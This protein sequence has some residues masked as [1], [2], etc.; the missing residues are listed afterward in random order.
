MVL[1]ENL[2]CG[3]SGKIHIHD[4][5]EKFDFAILTRKNIFLVFWENKFYDFD[6]KIRFCDVARKCIFIFLGFG[7]KCVFT[8]FTGN[9]SLTN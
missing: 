2:I 4:F 7:G 9:T 3:F 5:D 1:A 8:V 6:G